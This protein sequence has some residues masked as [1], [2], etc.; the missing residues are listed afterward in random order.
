MYVRYLRN[1]LMC[2]C[3]NLFLLNSRYCHSRTVQ[4]LI[5]H[6]E[7]NHSCKT[8]S[9]QC[10]QYSFFSHGHDQTTLKLKSS[11]YFF[12][13]H[14]S[15]IQPAIVQLPCMARSK[16]VYGKMWLLP[17]LLSHKQRSVNSETIKSNY[18]SPGIF[19]NC[20]SHVT[21]R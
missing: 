1:R 17:D 11:R 13:I 4:T 6:F 7:W 16:R 15:F 20:T 5:F 2:I 12:K 19:D 8:T 14:V 9:L 18:P 21:N 10:I 3:A